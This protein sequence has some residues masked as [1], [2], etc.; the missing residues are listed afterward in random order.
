MSQP[1]EPAAQQSV[2]IAEKVKFWQEQDKINQELITRVIRQNE[3]L[4]AHIKDHETLPIIAA[5]AG[6][7]A[8]EQRAAHKCTMQ[9][10]HPPRKW[11]IGCWTLAP[12]WNGSTE[13]KMA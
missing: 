2:H 3:L 9:Y 5:A 7:Q 8:V 10:P 1:N 11:R 12:I 6:R 13:Y 4:T